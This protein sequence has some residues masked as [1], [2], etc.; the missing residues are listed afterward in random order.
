MSLKTI[1]VLIVDDSALVRE[2]LQR[3]FSQTKGF[4]VVGTAADPLQAV[5]KIKEY[6]PDVLTLDLEMP[7]MDGL[8]FLERLMSVYP[9]PVVVVSSLTRQGSTAAVRALELGA[10]DVVAK[11]TAGLSNGLK[12]L[13]PEIVAKIKNAAAVNM[14]MLRR[15]VKHD[16]L[17][18][19]SVTETIVASGNIKDTIP[20]VRK[21]DR[22]VAIGASTGGTVAVKQILLDLPAN[23]PGI[24]I[25]LHMPAGF[26]A[27]YARSL[28]VVCRIQVKEATDGE[29]LS[30]GCAY[31]APG[32]KH[33][34]LEKNVKGFYLKLDS[35]SP[36][37]RHKPSVDKTFFSVAGSASPGSMGIILTGMGYDGARG[38]KE[39]HDRGFLTLAQDEKSSIVFGMPQKAIALN[40][41]D[42]VL[43]LHEIA[44]EIIRFVR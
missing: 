39:M 17:Q 37:N 30:T 32:G 13:F 43:P 25:V 35:G 2:V 31:V 15:Q 12:N 5:K 18:R 11:P 38:L 40:A 7:R 3:L 22:V 6:K 24:L 19:R 34:L 41:V 42:K 10:V 44:A 16:K 14:E 33:L 36:V 21:A 1:R 26:T 28:D 29:P 27:S 9:L 8:T 4:E 20:L 23:M